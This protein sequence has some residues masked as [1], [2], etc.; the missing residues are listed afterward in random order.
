[1]AL[2][3]EQQQV[4]YETRIGVNRGTSKPAEAEATEADAYGDLFNNA[5][6][7]AYNRAIENGKLAAIE[8]SESYSFTTE[9]VDLGNGNTAKMPVKYTP[10]T[11]L[12]RTGNIEYANLMNAKYRKSLNNSIEN[13]ILEER[14]QAQSLEISKPAFE[15]KLR[16]K[17]SMVFE[18]LD[19]DDRQNAKLY[20]EEKIV[21]NGF[22]VDKA[23]RQSQLIQDKLT[24][25]RDITNIYTE[26]YTRYY[27]TKDTNRLNQDIKEILQEKELYKSRIPKNDLDNIYDSRVNRLLARKNVYDALGIDMAEMNEIDNLSNTNNQTMQKIANWFNGNG[28]G[29]LE[30]G[31]KKITKEQLLKGIDGDKDKIFKEIGTE[32]VAFAKTYS[33]KYKAGIGFVKVKT[34]IRDNQRSDLSSD[35]IQAV[36]SNPEFLE[37]VYEEYAMSK[38]LTESFKQA[39]SS[40]SI[41]DFY[42]YLYSNDN[43]H[44]LPPT[45]ISNIKG[46]AQ[47]RNVDRLMGYSKLLKYMSDNSQY[48]KENGF[49]NDTSDLI[50]EL[51]QVSDLTPDNYRLV[52]DKFDSIRNDKELSDIY[53]M[54][55][56]SIF[57]KTQNIGGDFK[58]VADFNKYMDQQVNDLRGVGDVGAD[59]ERFGYMAAYKVKKAVM[60][61]IMKSNT[62]PTKDRVQSYIYEE[63]QALVSERKIAMSTSGFSPLAM[64]GAF[65]QDTETLMTTPTIMEFA[66]EL[67][68]SEAFSDG[69]ASVTR[70]INE[71]VNIMKS[72]INELGGNAL[73]S[74]LS[75]A[76]GYNPVLSKYK[77]Y[78]LENED[79]TYDYQI[80]HIGKETFD[81]VLLR[82]EAGDPLVITVEEFGKIADKLNNE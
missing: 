47:S 33:E 40:G 82:D 58:G 61:R 81:P 17:L 41:N 20:A 42:G 29:N 7:F 50:K 44:A 8:K 27:A 36:L 18:S 64:D 60:D 77:L 37:G 1:M 38:G 65:V 5:S 55:L 19:P 73:V 4:R 21:E 54:G 23:H 30:I 75:E 26:A 35:K 16:S 79:G 49:D 31:N 59:N 3:D 46:A 14:T 48:M 43:I 32:Y 68:H 12:G 63:A 51:G 52:M 22:Y 66:P 80:V 34:S 71:K 24:Y 15:K 57:D 72:T 56:K 6:R 2:K 53:Q 25:S 45:L 10:R 62:F 76:K 11:D 13:I 69:G 74:D 28:V 78:P 70:L 67:I 9:D 39:Q